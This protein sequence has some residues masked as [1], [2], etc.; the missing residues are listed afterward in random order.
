MTAKRLW[1]SSR[2]FVFGVAVAVAVVVDDDSRSVVASSS[3]VAAEADRSTETSADDGL[4]EKMTNDP[5]MSSNK[6][7]CMLRLCVT[8]DGRLYHHDGVLV[9]PWLGWWSSS[10]LPRVGRTEGR[11]SDDGQ[12]RYFGVCLSVR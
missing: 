7:N 1:I 9:A 11:N 10:K 8:V 6:N 12:K 4:E 5:T 3:S 2:W